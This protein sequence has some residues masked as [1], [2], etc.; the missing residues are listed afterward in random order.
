MTNFEGVTPSPVHCVEA[1]SHDELR[2]CDPKPRQAP[3]KPRGDV[4]QASGS[5]P[6]DAIPSRRG[7]VP[8]LDFDGPVNGLTLHDLRPEDMILR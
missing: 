4:D 6:D 1:T 5:Y 7:T 3:C 8:E 2:R